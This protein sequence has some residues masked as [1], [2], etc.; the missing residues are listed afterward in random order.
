MSSSL[1]VNQTECAAF[2][3]H[4]VVGTLAESKLSAGGATVAYGGR[5]HTLDP[6]D[7]AGPNSGDLR[8]ATRFTPRVCRQGI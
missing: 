3:V 2:E 6:G 4:T 7:F 1:A 8:T 5:L